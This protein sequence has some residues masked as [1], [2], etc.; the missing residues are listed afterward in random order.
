M[1]GPA[2]TVLLRAGNIG[3]SIASCAAAVLARRNAA[4]VTR[5]EIFLAAAWRAR[6]EIIGLRR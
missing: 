1:C 6:N 5:G 2:V 3:A 4:L